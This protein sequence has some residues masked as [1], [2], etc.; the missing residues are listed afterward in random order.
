M[1]RRRVSVSVRGLDRSI[2]VRRG[3]GGLRKVL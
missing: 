1:V 3:V 2:V